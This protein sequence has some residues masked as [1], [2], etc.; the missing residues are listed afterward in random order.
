M[1]VEGTACGAPPPRGIDPGIRGRE[2]RLALGVARASLERS[3]HQ[4]DDQQPGAAVRA[5]LPQL[6]ADYHRLHHHHQ[7]AHLPPYAEEHPADPGHV[8]DPAS[9]AGA[10]EAVRRRPP[11]HLPGDHAPVP[12]VWGEPLGMPGPLRCADAR[13]SGPLLVYYQDAAGGAGAARR[14]L[15]PALLPALSVGHGAAPAQRF[16]GIRPGSGWGR[17]RPGG[18][19]AHGAGGGLHVGLHEDDHPPNEWRRGNPAADPADDAV[20][21]PG[22]DRLHQPQ[23]SHR[24]VPVLDLL[25]PHPSPYPIR[26]DRQEESHSIEGPSS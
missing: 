8:G 22:D 23:P 10:P 14:S 3:H 26:H 11:A 12:R 16:P 17:P 7:R 5:P 15:E 19:P 6:R 2:G 24:A 25:Q 21:V 9:A 20:D 1:P 18:L 4:A 13:P